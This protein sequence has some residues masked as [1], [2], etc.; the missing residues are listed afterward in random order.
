VCS[1]YSRGDYPEADTIVLVLT[2][3]EPS[4]TNFSGL[5]AQLRSRKGG[6]FVS[7]LMCTEEDRIVDA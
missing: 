6:V 3:G 2:D 4:D 5:V 7:F 1:G